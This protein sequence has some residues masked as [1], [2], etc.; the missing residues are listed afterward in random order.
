MTDIN[1]HEH[2]LLGYFFAEGQS[3]QVSSH[4]GIDLSHDVHEDLVVVLHDGSV[5]HEL[6]NH[7]TVRI[8]LVLQSCIEYFLSGTIR[9]NDEEEVDLL[10]GGDQ[11]G[12]LSCLLLLGNHSGIH[13]FVEILV[14]CFLEVLNLGI[15]SE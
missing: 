8:D 12:V 14:D 11:L 9:D 10:L 13:I 3:P 5:L 2:G 6:R 7:W 1:A 15:V 4:L